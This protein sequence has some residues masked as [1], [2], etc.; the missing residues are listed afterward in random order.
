MIRRQLLDARVGT[1]VGEVCS[2][3]DWPLPRPL[4]RPRPRG[5]RGGRVP[6]RV[7]GDAS[8]TASAMLSDCVTVDL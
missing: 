6:T 1:K 5:T 8:F 4:P 2:G 7:R 3:H